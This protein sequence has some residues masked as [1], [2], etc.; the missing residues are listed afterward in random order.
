MVQKEYQE[1]LH[2]VLCQAEMVLVSRQV[3]DG[4]PLKTALTELTPTKKQME[5]E[6]LMRV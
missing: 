3:M 5:T 2:P 6:T 1:D 4:L